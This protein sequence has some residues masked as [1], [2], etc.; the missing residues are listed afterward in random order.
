MGVVYKAQDTRLDRFVALKF[1]PEGLA[2][3]RQAMERFRR[4]AKAASALNHP[5]ICTIYDIGE[6]NGK[7]FIAME[8]LDG[9]TLKYFIMGRPLDMEVLLDVGIEVAD[10]LDAAHSQGIVHR[11]IKPANIFVTKRGHAKILDFGLAKLRT[12]GGTASASS[13]E[14]MATEGIDPEHLTSPGSTL[15][16]VSYMSPEQV[17]AKPL[18]PRSDLFSFGVVLYEMATG[19]LPFRGESSAVI[20][21]SIM[22]RQPVPPV[23]L[24]PDLP[25][26]LERIIRKALEKDR[27][28]RYQHASDLRGDLRRLK[29]DSDSRLT[30]SFQEAMAIA[31]HRRVWPAIGVASLGLGA[32]LTLLLALNVG[33]LRDRWMHGTEA[34]QTPWK[35]TRLTADPGL[36][37][38]AALSPDGKL[39]AYAS[40]RSLDGELDLYIKQVVGGQPIRLTTDGMGNTMPDF[41]PDG[42]KIVFRSDREGGGIF[43]IPAFGGDAR[44][45]ARDGW[46]PKCS[47][48]GSQ[49]A[50]WVGDAG[51]AAAI[52]G[53]GT[54]WVVPVAG[55]P[56][57]QVGR[58]FT[59]AR[60][61]IWSPDGKHL[62]MVGYTSAKAYDESA[63]EWWLVP[64]NGGSAVRTGAHQAFVHGG[65]RALEPSSA[66]DFP[67]PA[68]WS[69]ST[70]MILFSAVSGS[71]SNLW[72]LGIAPRTGRTNGTLRRLTTG[73]GNDIN[74]SCA[75]SGALAFTNA[76]DRTDVWVMP[77]DLNRG[78]ANAA[79]ERITQGPAHRGY[80]SLSN[81]GRYVAFS[82][83]QSGQENI[84]IRDLVTGKE[85]SVDSSS[86]LQ[87]YPVVNAAGTRVA[88]SV[89]EGN[90]RVV[91]ASAP[92][93]GPEKLCEG[94]LRA[95]D[96]SRDEKTVLVFGGA[97]YQIDILD[98]ASHEQTPLLKHPNYSVLY[99][100]FS[101]D[102]LWVSFT[103]RTE[104]NRGHISI[105]RVDGPKPIPESAWITIA[106]SEAQ[107]WAN[108]SP[109]GKSLYFTS[110]RD[111]HRCLWG[112]R[113][114]ATSHRP[115]GDPFLVQHL[116]GRLSYQND[117]WSAGGGRIGLVL[118]EVVGNIWMMSRARSP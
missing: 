107:D 96:W 58:N 33:D 106:P 17:R 20:F 18:D 40:D 113:L 42:S 46:N 88:F 15:G 43:E 36:S 95:T 115:L 111:G 71:T 108:W 110:S 77:F 80:A 84:W 2:H 7:A 63:I 31:P 103:V 73:V 59:A 13:I 60:Y 41:S 52:P 104:P 91:Y 102:N 92:G 32:L 28:L 57:Q 81:N 99:G 38:F 90:K 26:E 1:L 3:D 69:A 116:H 74:A 67:I 97:P 37:G 44:L 45:L 30:P 51:V 85:S 112:Q 70:D 66:P 12:A 16:T 100:R 22:G 53:T 56:P 94:C 65:L 79:L 6:E 118:D 75:S 49:V 64:T 50:Y 61:P 62:L 25:P 105:A 47:P 9:Q 21:E 83:D 4:E 98:L 89:F 27:D 5:N 117:G 78:K 35:V 8:F 34:L 48:D 72:G 76:Q 114:D 39:V 29:R 55:G 93:G 14:T 68:G 19:Q 109:D 101:P 54:V 10:A 87:L 23:R 11:D 86:F 24:N 82:S